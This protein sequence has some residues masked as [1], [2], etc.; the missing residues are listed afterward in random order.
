MA[1]SGLG[2]SQWPLE[3]CS[4]RYAA[5]LSQTSHGMCCE[6]TA[7]RRTKHKHALKQE[8]TTFSFL[9][10][11][12]LDLHLRQD[13]CFRLRFITINIPLV[14]GNEVLII[15]QSGADEMHTNGL[16]RLLGVGISFP[17]DIET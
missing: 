3:I 10:R 16:V 9:P 11:I 7:Q 5:T 17:G 15:R 13:C 8:P 12:A 1:H 4:L 2:V 14:F 6:Q